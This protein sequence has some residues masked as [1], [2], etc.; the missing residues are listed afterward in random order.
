MV[1]NVKIKNTKVAD[2]VDT[3][4]NTTRGD[5][6]QAYNTHSYIIEGCEKLI[7]WSFFVA[8]SEKLLLII[9]KQGKY[10]FFNF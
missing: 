7:F 9:T 2:I 3:I 8:L 1:E 6:G 5:S 4:D 10:I